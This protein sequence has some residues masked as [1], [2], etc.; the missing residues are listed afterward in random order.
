MN[1]E[2]PKVDNFFEDAVPNMQIKQFRR[3]FRMDPPT[4]H[5]LGEILQ[6]DEN[7]KLHGRKPIDFKK[8]L[9]MTL[10]FLGT[11]MPSFQ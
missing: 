7:E 3:W 6:N 1:E 8:R 10:T 4:F 11:Q 9:A 2:V 5:A